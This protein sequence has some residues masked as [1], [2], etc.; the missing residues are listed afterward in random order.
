M[1]AGERTNRQWEMIVP[2]MRELANITRE[3]ARAII[4]YLIAENEE[5]RAE[6]SERAAGP[7]AIRSRSRDLPAD[8]SA[9]SWLSNRATV[10]SS[11]RA[12]ANQ[13]TI[14]KTRGR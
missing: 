5:E 9:W 7:E 3:E 1:E 11:L 10:R 8:R 4:A 12:L 13:R 2:Q 14:G 6:R